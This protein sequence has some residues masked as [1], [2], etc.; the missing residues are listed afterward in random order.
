MVINL[1]LKDIVKEDKFNTINL[2]GM[3]DEAIKNNI[4][5]M[6]ISPVYYEESSKTSI[7]EVKIIVDALN[8]YLEENNLN[9]KLY[10]A[11]LIRDNFA[12]LK[13]YING[14]IG[15]L[16]ETDY[17]LLNV[18]ESEDINELI[19]IIYEF[20]LRNVIPILI[21]VERINE[22]KDNYKKIEKLLNEECLFMLDPCALKGEYGKKVQKVTKILLKNKLYRFIGFEDKIKG[23]YLTSEVQEIGKKSLLNLNN[24]KGAKV[25][26]NYKKK[27]KT[28]VFSKLIYI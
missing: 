4:T 1:I 11:N 17:V 22:V 14:N 16:G 13:D 15:K 9:L 7:N 23:E 3:I 27:I 24:T 2:L 21:G 12:S 25:N 19:E 18:E 28:G 26:L 6:V 20:N 10:S 8:E 5:R